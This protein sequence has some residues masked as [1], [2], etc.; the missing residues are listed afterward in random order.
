MDAAAR[1]D[2]GFL[3]SRDHELIVLER[4]ALPLSLIEIENPSRL[5]REI[6]VT[7]ENPTPVLPGTDGVLM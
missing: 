5:C 6:R 7:R 2:A 4:F 3:V 1:L